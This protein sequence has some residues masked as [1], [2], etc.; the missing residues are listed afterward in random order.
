[1][2]KVLFLNAFFIVY[3]GP[4]DISPFSLTSRYLIANIH[5]LNL[6]VS[7]K[8]A[9]IHIHTKAPGPPEN[10]AVA[11]PIILPVP[12][13]AASA[14]I[15]AEKGDTSPVPLFL[16][17]ASL[18]NTLCNA[19]PRFLHGRN[20]NRT[21]R[22]IPVPTSSTNIT[23]PHTKE[24]IA[25]TISFTLSITLHLPFSNY[26]IKKGQGVDHLVLM[27]HNSTQISEIVKF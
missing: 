10:M 17:L 7:P 18:L 2:P 22:K 23:G 15:N 19:Y 16:V 13:V 9:E 5:S 27:F 20:L 14:V 25:P 26:G 24:S 12:I 11:T 8:H 4:P 1:M 21:V 3:I 6:E